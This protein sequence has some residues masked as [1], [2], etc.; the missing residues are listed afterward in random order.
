[1]VHFFGTLTDPNACNR[2]Q[3]FIFKQNSKR[4]CDSRLYIVYPKLKA[5]IV[6]VRHFFVVF[7]LV[8]YYAVFLVLKVH[9][10]LLLRLLN[11]VLLY[12]KSASIELLDVM[13]Q[14]EVNTDHDYPVQLGREESFGTPKP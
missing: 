2:M 6:L 7:G 1:M 10:K 4:I 13:R 3:R 14:H 5:K 9:I 8:N 11:H 12:N